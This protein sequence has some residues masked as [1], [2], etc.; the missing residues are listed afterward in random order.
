MAMVQAAG[1]HH[2]R[3]SSMAVR[4]VVSGPQAVARLQ[5]LEQ[6]SPHRSRAVSADAGRLSKPQRQVLLKMAGGK[7]LLKYWSARKG[8]YLRWDVGPDRVPSDK[9][10]RV[11]LDRQLISHQSALMGRPSGEIVLTDAGRRVAEGGGRDG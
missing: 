11:L 9:T 1:T 7:R 5:A 2:R 8:L 6:E 10:L 4:W 3:R